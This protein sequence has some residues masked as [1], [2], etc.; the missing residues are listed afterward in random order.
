LLSSLVAADAMLKSIAVI[1]APS[2][3]GLRPTGVEYLPEA[4][5][6]AGLLARLQARHGGRV[7]APLY[8]DV[9]DAE[10]GS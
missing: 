5:L 7:S 1:E 3:L 2:I 8:S 10:T 6:G 4:L 9:R